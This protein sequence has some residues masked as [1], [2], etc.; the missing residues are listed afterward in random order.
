MALECMVMA[1]M[2]SIGPSSGSGSGSSPGLDRIDNLSN[3]F[4]QSPYLRTAVRV[5]LFVAL[6]GKIAW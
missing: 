5:F 4:Y 1:C 6:G 2:S 3:A